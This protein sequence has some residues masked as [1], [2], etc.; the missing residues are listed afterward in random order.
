MSRL[1]PY[2]IS[3]AGLWPEAGPMEKKKQPALQRCLDRECDRVCLFL[4]IWLC[5]LRARLCH[6]CWVGQH[7]ARCK[8]QQV[9]LPHVLA[10]HPQNL[11]HVFMPT[12]PWAGGQESGVVGFAQSMSV[13][14]NNCAKT[15]Q[16]LSP[17]GLVMNW[18]IVPSCWVW[19]VLK[20]SGGEHIRWSLQVWGSDTSYFFQVL[21][22][23][24]RIRSKAKNINCLANSILKMRNKHNT[25]KWINSPTF[26]P[27]LDGIF[28]FNAFQDNLFK[29]NFSKFF[30]ISVERA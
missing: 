13:F 22:Y 17:K 19:E 16:F 21:S 4:Q 18:A 20:D 14:P 10:Q 7:Q 23:A 29:H 27:F 12:S 9:G 11:C 8:R 24:G 30:M 3:S 25:E 26:H 28:L 5:E 6:S 1:L 15:T 2:L